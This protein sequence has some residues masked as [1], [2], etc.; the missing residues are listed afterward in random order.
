M[1]ERRYS[2]DEV[3]A[4]FEA[5][6]EG[7]TSKSLQRGTD[8][9]LT[10]ADLQQI[11]AQ[12]GLAPDAVAQAAL[13]V[14]LRP[15]AASQSFLGLPIGVERT[16]A[17][18]RWLTDAE[19]DNVVGEM[20][21]VFRAPGKVSASGSFREWRNGNLRASLEPT[22][23]GHRLSLSTVKGSVRPMIGIGA[24]LVTAGAL[25]WLVAILANQLDIGALTGASIS[26]AAGLGIVANNLL[27][28][29]GWARRRA[30]QLDA[31]ATRVAL[32]PGSRR[33]G[34][35]PSTD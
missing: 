12:V 29:K 18:N 4:I 30:Q 3:T 28:L 24:G 17:L 33:L 16:I 35:P 32:P 6:T 34:P 13:S 20:R 21:S 19:W 7:T 15:H 1:T 25:A 14:D 27:S 26:A 8:A 9:G 31:I 10:L 23:T 5:A 11:G 22:E 2:D